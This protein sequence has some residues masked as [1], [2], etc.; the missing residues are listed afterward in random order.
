VAAVL[1]VIAIPLSASSGRIVSETLGQ[2]D[3][4]AVAGAWAAPS[5]WS[6]ASVETDRAGIRVRAYGPLPAPDAQS[7]REALDAAGHD[8]VDVV[9]ELVPLETVELPAG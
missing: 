6:V 5:G 9:V 4:E 8:A 1:V 2:R 3:V 7:L